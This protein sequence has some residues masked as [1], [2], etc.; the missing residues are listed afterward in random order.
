MKLI[1]FLPCRQVIVSNDGTVSL[2]TVLENINVNIQQQEPNE[3]SKPVIVPMA[4][5]LITQWQYEPD[6]REDEYLQKIEIVHPDGTLWSTIESTIPPPNQEIYCRNIV[7]FMGLSVA[8]SGEMLVK[9]FL[10]KQLSKDWQIISKYSL[11]IRH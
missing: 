5:E 9:L 2:I 4:W 6:D 1:Y 8:Q 11:F 10:K 3:S 7:K